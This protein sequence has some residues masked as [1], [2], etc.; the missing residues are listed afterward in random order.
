MSQQTRKS[1][2]YQKIAK[3]RIFSIFVMLITFEGKVV[4]SSERSHF[5]E[6]WLLYHSRLLKQKQNSRRLGA[7]KPGFWYLG[8]PIFGNLATIIIFS[9]PYWKQFSL[10]KSLF[11]YFLAF[12]M[13][14][15]IENKP[16]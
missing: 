16:C 11:G 1:E 4:E 3:K 12:P 10:F 15:K 7:E 8:N 13:R 14:E 6:N 2:I 9:N 5:V